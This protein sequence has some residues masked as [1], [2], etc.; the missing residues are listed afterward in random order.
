MSGIKNAPVSSTKPEHSNQS[1]TSNQ[2]YTLFRIELKDNYPFTESQ[3]V[4][5][6]LSNSSLA[7]SI[8]E[9]AILTG[10]TRQ[11]VYYELAYLIEKNIIEVCPHS[12]CSITRKNL[13][14][15]KLKGGFNV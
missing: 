2:H 5:N 9:I 10:L 11:Q 14:S 4:V 12:I 13:R 6:L 8:Y 15:Y 3:L 7:L 1:D